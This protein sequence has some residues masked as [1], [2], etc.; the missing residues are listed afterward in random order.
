MRKQVGRERLTIQDGDGY[1][2]YSVSPLKELTIKQA[3]NL[4]AT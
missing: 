4:Q 1:T 2:R 3:S